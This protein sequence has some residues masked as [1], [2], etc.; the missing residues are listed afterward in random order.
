MY[1]E[2]L[3]VV[4]V[5]LVMVGM[6]EVYGLGILVGDFIEYVSLVEVYGNDGFCVLVLVKINFGYI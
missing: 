5:D 6:V 2:V 4:G 1:W 3:D